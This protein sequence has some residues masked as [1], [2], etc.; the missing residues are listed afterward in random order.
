[1]KDY[2]ELVVTASEMSGDVNAVNYASSLVAILEAK[3]SRALK[4]RQAIETRNA[5]TSSLGTINLPDDFVELV[6]IFKGDEELYAI[7]MASVMSDHSTGYC[8][9]GTKIHITEK[10]TPI[11]MRFYQKLPSLRDVGCNWLLLEAPDIYLYGLVNEIAAKNLEV[12][13]VAAI[14][15]YLDQLIAEFVASNRANLITGES[16]TSLNGVHP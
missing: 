11:T 5:T 13:K 9:M 7:P 1:M 3:L 4:V 8:I 16:H 6:S 12:Q 2:T 14:K 10:S 15:P